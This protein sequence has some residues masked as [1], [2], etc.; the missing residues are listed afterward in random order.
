MDSSAQAAGS[1]AGDESPAALLRTTSSAK[2]ARVSG[3]QKRPA[4]QSCDLEA[5]RYIGSEPCGLRK[6]G[7]GRDERSE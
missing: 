4:G 6:V 3:L 1:A 2:H 5:G 7:N